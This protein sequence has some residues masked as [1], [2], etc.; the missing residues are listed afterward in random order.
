MINQLT[1]TER[2]ALCAA[3]SHE[4]DM[5]DDGPLC[6]TISR[7]PDGFRMPSRAA[8]RLHDARLCARDGYAPP[9]YDDDTGDDE[10]DDET[11][12]R[13]HVA[14]KRRDS[15]REHSFRLPSQSSRS[16]VIDAYRSMNIVW[17]D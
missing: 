16:D 12:L 9:A 14:H 1:Q 15:L 5:E 8:V 3:S 2:L 6:V 11:T 7:P 4:H 17:K 10:Q 13:E